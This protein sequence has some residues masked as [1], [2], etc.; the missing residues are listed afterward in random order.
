VPSRF[1]STS[2]PRASRPR[3]TTLAVA[4]LFLVVGSS[5]ASSLPLRATDWEGTRPIVPAS[6]APAPLDAAALSR[7][8]MP[9]GLST[10]NSVTGADGAWQRVAPPLGVGASRPGLVYDSGGNRLITFGGLE[11]D[12]GFQTDVAAFQLPAGTWST[13]VTAGTPPSGRVYH[14]MVYDPVGHR[15]LVFGGYSDSL[16]DDVWQLTLTGTPTWSQLAPDGPGP[17]PRAGAAA[18]YDAAGQRMIVFGGFDNLGASYG[19][20]NDVWAL[21]L[22]GTPTWTQLAPAGTG[23]TPRFD[24]SAAYD[25]AG[26][27]L[28]LFAGVD[29]QLNNDVW[30]LSL[31]G[32]PTWASVAT[33]GTP[34]TPRAEQSA[35]FDPVS[36]RLAVFGGYDALD[37]KN[38]LSEL[39]LS[40]SP[41]HWTPA[42][43][44][45][46]IVARFSAAAA[47]AGD[48]R[49]YVY[50][51]SD[52]GFGALADVWAISV[53]NPTAWQTYEQ[54]LPPRLQEVMVLDTQ[55]D[56]LVVFGGTDGAYKNDTYVHSMVSGT[57]WNPLATAGTPPGPRRLHTGV[58]DP[59]G[60]RLIVFGGFDDTLLGDLW[61]LS[62]SGTPT[63]SPIVAS[64]GGPSPRGG[65]VAIYDPEG[66]RMLVFGGYDGVSPPANRI[67]DTW[68]L[69]LSGAPAWT[70][71]ATGPGP[72]ARS[73]SS[74]VYDAQH[75]AMVVF[76]G[77]D[78]NYCNDAWSL[79][80]DS[81]AWTQLS[82]GG[83]LPGAREEN[84]AVFDGKRDRMVIFGGYNY[85]LWN[86]RDLWS[87]D[88]GSPPAWSTLSPTG[89]WPSGRWGMKAIY[90][91][92]RDGMWLYGGWDYSYDRDLWFLQWKD[93]PS[94]GVIATQSAQ[95][96]ANV[97]QLVWNSPS[98]IRNLA[99]VERSADGN[100]WTR[101][102]TVL[103]TRTGRLEFADHGVAPEQTRAWRVR[104]D[105]AGKS[106]ASNPAWLTMPGT[107]GIE[108]ASVAFG[109]RPAGAA[110]APGAVAVECALPRAGN[111]R[112][113]LLDVSGRRLDSKQLAMAAGVQ[114]IELGHDLPTGLFFVR[115]SAA[116]GVAR[117]KVLKLQ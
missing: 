53:A 67:G 107:T 78:P 17:S 26:P 28:L 84:S 113:E 90:D 106:L 16:L 108:P 31:D 110:S 14:A 61:Q 40:S 94:T 15:L 95:A 60:D 51:G 101:V 99:K 8:A 100:V 35:V 5:P 89:T 33:D 22:G 104:V 2:A 83:S 56:R 93:A 4:L 102:G 55:R 74:A 52:Y 43:P 6:Q 30:R 85:N 91:A 42:N 112:V 111:A 79:S 18:I 19:L 23:P 45:P 76:G 57:G 41:A 46:P 68:S 48:G 54:L 97:A 115:F 24:S 50:G 66:Q 25:P 71:L 36:H 29:T 117:T 69:D 59:V 88:L 21:S 86:Y 3:P 81:P 73:S 103:P 64:G 58:Y 77:T 82:P 92:N 27:A 63:W 9:S 13:L 75:H 65:H 80:L 116:P 62:F 44:Q 34:P 98:T 32:S 96:S 109:V 47:L 37:V 72:S 87:L 70:Q 10:L 20:E 7:M 12:Y 49:M 39:D 114:R 1:V 38:D 105:V 11:R